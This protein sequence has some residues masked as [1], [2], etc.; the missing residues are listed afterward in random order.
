[1]QNRSVA[2]L[3]H[4]PKVTK[5]R[6]EAIFN[7]ILRWAVLL[8]FAIFFGIP[9]L[10]LVLAITKSDNQLLGLHPLAF[11][12]L[13][14]IGRAWSNLMNFNN[15]Q[16]VRWAYNSVT[17]VFAAVTLSLLITLPTGYALGVMRFGGRRVLLWLTLIL[18]ILPSAWMR[19]TWRLGFQV[20][21]VLL[22]AC[23]TLFPKAT[24]LSHT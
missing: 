17:Y 20:R 19:A 5:I 12:S 22:F 9:L 7:W 10:W 3:T 1:M 2:S 21:R 16:V 8:L 14:H 6:P 23:E 15:G 18:M 4:V 24:P 13:E 11:G